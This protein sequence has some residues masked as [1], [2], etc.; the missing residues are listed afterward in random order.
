MDIYVDYLSL[1]GDLT[2]QLD[3]LTALAQQKVEVVR[4]SDLIALDEVLR[5][6][7]AISLALR[8]LEQR[9]LDLLNRLGLTQVPLEQLA[10]R[11]P[12]ALQPQASQTVTELRRSYGHYRT[13]SEL[14]R[15]TLEVHL[16]QV[17]QVVAAHNGTPVH[18]AGY[19]PPDA[20]LP[21]N[22]KTDF[23]A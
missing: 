8:G 23:R 17:E 2:K 18:G 13:A 21:K 4:R 6:E 14:A 16:H 22:M 9:R 19:T 12:A 15:T 1:L 3:R 20:E 11:Y 5:Q 7:Q 10:Q